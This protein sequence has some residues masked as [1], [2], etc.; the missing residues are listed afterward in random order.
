MDGDALIVELPETGAKLKLDPWDG[1]IFTATLMPSGPFAA[2]A[3]N[4]GPSPY[5]FVQWQTDKTPKLD[6]FRLILGGDQA[7]EF[8]R[9]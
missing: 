9:R 5:G 6:A 4:L 2:V 8:R 1:D 3:A 7:Y